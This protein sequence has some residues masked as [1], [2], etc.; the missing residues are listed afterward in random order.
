VD[1]WVEPLADDDA[2]ALPPVH[3]DGVLRVHG[4]EVVERRDQDSLAALLLSSASARIDCPALSSEAS[5][6]VGNA[7]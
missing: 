7:S 3:L 6:S 5:W 2:V 4:G 1:V